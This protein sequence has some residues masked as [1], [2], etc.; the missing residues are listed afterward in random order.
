MSTQSPD[1]PVVGVG[2]G[3][4]PPPTRVVVV[5]L[6]VPFW[7]MVM[8]LIKVVIAAIPAGMILGLLAMLASLLY[9]G[10]MAAIG[11]LVNK[12]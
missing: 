10:G 3:T 5:D 7:Q 2:P 8:L 12:P 6:D 1:R 9:Y 4:I 11:G